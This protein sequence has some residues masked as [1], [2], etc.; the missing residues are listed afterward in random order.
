MII[1]KLLQP[2]FYISVQ[3]QLM[4]CSKI[5]Y[6]LRYNNVQDIYETSIYS[7]KQ[8]RFADGHSA[9]VIDYVPNVLRNIQCLHLQGHYR[10][11]FSIADFIQ[12][13]YCKRILVL[14]FYRYNT[15]YYSTSV[16]TWV[17]GGTISTSKGK[18]KESEFISESGI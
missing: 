2:R 12:R 1:I 15:I 3:N 5:Q 10:Y 8:G 17:T 18:M 9:T 16:L 14:L 11:G 7:R 6:S 4:G 13:L